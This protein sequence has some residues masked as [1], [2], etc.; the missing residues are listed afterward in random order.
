MNVFML[1]VCIVMTVMILLGSF[2]FLVYFSSEED[3]NVA[4]FPKVIV[5]LGLTLVCLT[6]LML[7]LDV[8]N[9]QSDGGFDMEALWNAVYIA[10]G[11][12][13]IILIPSTLFYYEAEDP[14]AREAQCW[15][16]LKFEVS[17]VVI[18]TTI[19]VIFWL[20]WGMAEIPIED[21]T[22]NV[23]LVPLE[24]IVDCT[25]LAQRV[26]CSDD[27]QDAT[28]RLKSTPI[29]YFMAIVAFFGW[30][31]LVLFVG[32]G[33]AALPMDLLMEFTTRP[34]SIDLQEY[35]KQKMLLNERSQKLIEVGK[36]LGTD[37]HRSKD[38]RV[39]TTYNKFK[40]AVFFLEKDWER[41]KIAYKERGGNPIRY[42]FQ[43]VC[44]LVSVGLSIMWLLHLLVYVFITPPPT[45]F[46]N[47][48][49]IELDDI[50]PLFGVLAYGL[51]AFYLLFC[52][53]K[54]N[55]KFGVR[56]FCI[57]IHPMRVGATLINSMLFNVWLLQLCSFSLIQFCWTAFR[58][59]ARFTSADLIFGQQVHYLQGLSWFFRHNIFLYALVLMVL[60][61][62][63]YLCVWPTDKRA[64]EDEDEGLMM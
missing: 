13:A 28:V 21:F 64:L 35:A 7:P 4:Y 2:Y 57:P 29:V 51:F 40:Q 9:R 1:I 32:I 60:S 59:Y 56:F 3:R 38:R 61:T 50:F 19:Y 63:L 36:K 30:F 41:V 45:L 18:V 24:Q 37:A 53:L 54:G 31:F 55:M 44:G 58:S 33:L 34:Q 16:A 26:F 22:A 43:C 42:F 48:L 27:P 62:M 20:L 49:F 5:V 15:T 14:E 6:V 23:T 17:T 8:A 52:L 47:S 46:L 12:F 39:R 11:L 25:D 10:Q